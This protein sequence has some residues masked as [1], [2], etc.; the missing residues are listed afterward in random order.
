[1][2]DGNT[3]TTLKSMRTVKKTKKKNKLIVCR[4]C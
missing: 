1:M 2:T 3:P 4:G